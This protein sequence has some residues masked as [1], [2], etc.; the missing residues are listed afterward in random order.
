MKV[1]KET[2]RQTDNHTNGQLDIG[3]IDKGKINKQ[4][5]RQMKNGI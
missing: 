3:Q 5:Y 1:N 2:N 4:T